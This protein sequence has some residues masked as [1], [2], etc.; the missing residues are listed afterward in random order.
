M[1]KR[2]SDNQ[3]IWLKNNATAKVWKNRKEFLDT[4]NRIF[5]LSVSSSQ[6]N[7]LLLY[8]EI[9]PRTVQTES[10]FTKEQKRWLVDNATSGGYKDCKE[11]TE[12]FNKKFN[13]NRDYNNIYSYLHNWGISLNTVFNDKKY[14]AE[15]DKWLK[16]NFNDLNYEEIA[17]RFNQKFG[18]NKTA[19]G[20]SHRCTRSLKLKKPS[21]RFKKG[22]V[23]NALPIGTISNRKKEKYIKV[24][25]SNDKSAWQPLRKVIYEKHHGEIPKG[26]CVVSLDG[27]RSNVDLRNLDCIDRRGTAIMAKSGWWTDNK[28][29]TADGI[30]WCNLYCVA[31]D[32][33]LLRKEKI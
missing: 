26:Y 10:L 19:I 13:Q 11:L 9:K 17:N 25:D 32:K 29:I 18:T 5:G 20:I 30:R 24:S 1:N 31:K 27:D 8:Y 3:I 15:M 14:T 21:T 16:D 6:F 12:V 28:V 23:I 4:F 2:Y 22:D 7:N 33:G